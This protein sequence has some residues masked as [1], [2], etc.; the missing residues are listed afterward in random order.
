MV[1]GRGLGQ[2][3]GLGEA[4]FAFGSGAIF[5]C[6]NSGLDRPEGL[7]RLVAVDEPDVL[8]RSRGGLDLLADGLLPE[9]GCAARQQR[10]TRADGTGQESG[11]REQQGEASPAGPLLLHAALRL[12][13][14]DPP[15]RW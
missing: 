2:Q 7:R 5:L 14:P 10:R 1:L 8:H 4:G 6:P 15:R 3:D 12:R 13:T 9:A 11:N